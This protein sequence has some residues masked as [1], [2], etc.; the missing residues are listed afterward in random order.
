MNEFSRMASDTAHKCHCQTAQRTAALLLQDID[1]ELPDF[2]AIRESMALQYVEDMS[3]L[4]FEI[5]ANAA[6]SSAA[7]LR[8]FIETQWRSAAAT[9]HAT[10][11]D[12][13]RPLATQFAN[14]AAAQPIRQWSDVEES[15]LRAILEQGAIDTWFQPIFHGRALEL[16]GY[17]CLARAT[18]ADGKIISP[19]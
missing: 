14:L 3:L 19:K 10:W 6:F 17:E 7:Q 15:P 12:H 8:D 2:S 11:L 13:G 5:S 16:W 4:T 18:D 9:I 1:H